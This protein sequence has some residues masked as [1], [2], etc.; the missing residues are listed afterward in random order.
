M[1][2]LR[3]VKVVGLLTVMIIESVYE[4]IGRHSIWVMTVIRWI[5]IFYDIDEINIV[6]WVYV[7]SFRS[8]Q[9]IGLASW[10]LN[11][12]SE[13]FNFTLLSSGSRI[14]A[15][16]YLTAISHLSCHYFGNITIGFLSPSRIDHSRNHLIL[17][18]EYIV[19]AFF[20]ILTV[21]TVFL[22]IAMFIEII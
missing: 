13:N 16:I 14:L 7:L 22:I 12:V 19:Q 8:T 11:A 5:K 20:Y 6:D 1:I 2:F 21:F 17:K 3:F 9:H 4:K 15:V 18:I 10:L